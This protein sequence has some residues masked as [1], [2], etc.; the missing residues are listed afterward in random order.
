MDI[1]DNK[2]CPDK[3]K[4]L[5][6]LFSSEKMANNEKLNQEMKTVINIHPSIFTNNSQGINWSALK[7][8]LQISD[9]EIN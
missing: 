7:T 3:F 2:K 5:L 6:K 1:F 9:E 4:Y 8:K